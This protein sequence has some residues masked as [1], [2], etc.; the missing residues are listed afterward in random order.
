MKFDSKSQRFY[1]GL[2]L[3]CLLSGGCVSSSKYKS[4]VQERNSLMAERDKLESQ[5]NDLL[6]ANRKYQQQKNQLTDS[7]DELAS[8]VELADYVAQKQNQ[9]L[10]AMQSKN[11]GLVKKLT[12]ELADS[13]IKIDVLASG[14][15][16]IMPEEILFSPGSARVN[17]NGKSLL[18]KIKPDLVLSKSMIEVAGYTDNTKVTGRLRRMY[19]TNWELAGARASSVVRL[20]I[21]DGVDPSSIVAVSYGDTRPIASNDTPEGRKE[22]RRIEIHLLPQHDSI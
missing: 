19:P 1:L 21:D 12:D 10:A 11:A 14:I 2:G 8:Q 13:R 16:V 22:N 18:S 17:K 5:R 3:V 7:N 15:R 9:Q 6:A 4:V 20:F